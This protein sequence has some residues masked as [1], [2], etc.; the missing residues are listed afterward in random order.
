V[1]LDDVPLSIREHIWSMHD[2]AP[3]H[4]NLTDQEFLD[5]MHPPQ[6][7]SQ[8]GSTKC[9]PHLTE[10]SSTYM[11]FQFIQLQSMTYQLFDSKLNVVVAPQKIMNMFGSRS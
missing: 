9:H 5:N 7:T 8:R 1:L 10:L 3:S 4:F 11:K 6:Q 2:A